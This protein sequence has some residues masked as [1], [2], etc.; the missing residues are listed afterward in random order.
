[1]DARIYLTCPYCQN[2]FW[3]VIEISGTYQHKEIVVC[4]I[5]ESPGCDQMFG[6]VIKPKFH[7]MTYRMEFVEPTG[8]E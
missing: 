3:Q 2:Q 1:M 6:V 8:A 7:T 5:D 4:D